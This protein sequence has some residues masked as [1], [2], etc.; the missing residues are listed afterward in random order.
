MKTTIAAVVIAAI[1]MLAS[2]VAHAGDIG[3]YG[4]QFEGFIYFTDDRGACK[5]SMQTRLDAADGRKFYGCWR[6]V[7]GGVRFRWDG[8]S[9][10]KEKFLADAN[11]GATEYGEAVANAAQ[12]D[13][14]DRKYRTNRKARAQ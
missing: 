10:D 6:P 2:C 7:P 12:Q 9:A 13:E 3:V 11:I 4:N 1:V 8:E 5:N 14:I